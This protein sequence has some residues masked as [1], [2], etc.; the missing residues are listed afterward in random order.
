MTLICVWHS[1]A[2]GAPTLYRKPKWKA[3]IQESGIDEALPQNLAGGRSAAKTSG[4]RLMINRIL[5]SLAEKSNLRVDSVISVS[6][7]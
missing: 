4:K 2:I 5:K 6:P 7:C 3:G 1:Q